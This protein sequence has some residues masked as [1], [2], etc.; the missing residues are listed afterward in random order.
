MGTV[1]ADNFSDGAGT[2]APDFAT[3]LKVSGA[4]DTSG[5]A[6]VGTAAS[7]GLFKTETISGTVGAID[8]TTS[9]Q[10]LGSAVVTAGTWLVWG[11]V[12]YTGAASSQTMKAWIDTTAT[13]TEPALSSDSQMAWQT[14]NGGGEAAWGVQARVRV[15][16]GA[17]TF[18]LQGKGSIDVGASLRGVIY[19]TRLTL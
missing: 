8:P 7:P 18:Y 3:G 11:Q 17:A 13:T 19:A 9:G 14:V 4:F 16:A 2:G 5:D 15:A 6:G 1:R 10:T 12:S